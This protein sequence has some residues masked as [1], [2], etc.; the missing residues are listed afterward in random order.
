VLKNE[1]VMIH[2]SPSAGAGSPPATIPSAPPASSKTPV[3]P[4]RSA[5]P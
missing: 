5:A 3:A 1:N 2:P 4:P